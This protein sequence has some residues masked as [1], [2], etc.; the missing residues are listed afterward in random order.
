MKVADLL[1]YF[2]GTH[3]L[4]VKQSVDGVEYDE[5][6]AVPKCAEAKVLEA[7]TSAVKTG[8][9][10][11]TGGALLIVLVLVI[12]L[13]YG[14]RKRMQDL[15]RRRDQSRMSLRKMAEPRL[16]SG[17]T[18]SRRSGFVEVA[19]R[20]HAAVSGSRPGLRGRRGL[21]SGRRFG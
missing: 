7:A 6:V 5:T 20:P 13:P 17:S 14:A 18:M 4:T 11:V 9:L 15:L 8:L 16:R 21:W 3:S 10:W 12:A 2:S 19:V 1:A